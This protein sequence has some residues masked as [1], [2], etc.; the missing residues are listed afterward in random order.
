MTADSPDFSGNALITGSQPL[1][2]APIATVPTTVENITSIVQ[3]AG[4]QVTLA[5]H[6][7]SYTPGSLTTYTMPSITAGH[8]YALDYF[9]LYLQATT[10][11]GDLEVALFNGNATFVHRLSTTGVPNTC[12]LP[13]GGMIVPSTFALQ[14]QVK[15]N[16]G[17]VTYSASSLVLVAR[18]VLP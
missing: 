17:S 8:V 16:S 2:G 5:E 12:E 3:A 7:Q 4:T 15:N 6:N 11:A 9:G 1:T 14:V 13:L 10:A 18:D